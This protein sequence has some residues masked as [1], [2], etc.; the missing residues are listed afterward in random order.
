MTPYTKTE[1]GFELQFGVNHLAHFLM[2]NLLL[3]ENL[4]NENGGRIVV[5]ASRAHRFVK[6]IRFEDLNWEKDYNKKAAY[7][8]SKLANIYF[9]KELDKRLKSQGKNIVAV[10]LHPGVGRCCTDKSAFAKFQ[11]H[12]LRKPSIFLYNGS[13]KFSRTINC[14][15]IICRA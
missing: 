11:N 3:K 10:A 12:Y 2:T 5:V 14:S 13:N 1:D 7:G 4:I 9:A 15:G 6:G 8:Q